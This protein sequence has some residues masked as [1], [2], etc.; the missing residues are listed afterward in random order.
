MSPKNNSRRPFV[1]VS[2]SLLGVVGLAS[3][4]FTLKA[5]AG[6]APGILKCVSIGA[7]RPAVILS[8]QV[9]GDYEIFDLRVKR[10]NEEYSI[11]SSNAIDHDMDPEERNKLEENGVV[12]SG[13]VITLVE[14]F[15]RGVFT[16]ALRT[17][18]QYDL[19]LY[20]LPGTIRSR[21]TPNSK[22]ASFEAIVIEGEVP[23][24]RP[25]RMRCTFDHSI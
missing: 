20:A 5:S 3:L 4:A 6:S 11:K 17:P 9:P 8:G 13:R 24:A 2:L 1:I 23:G 18:D 7:T 25:L 15:K 21:I 16:V 10:G 22:K 19:R 14:D 12:S